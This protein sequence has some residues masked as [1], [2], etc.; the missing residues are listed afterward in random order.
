MK[1]D[2]ELLLTGK[3]KGLAPG[4]SIEKLKET[5]KNPF[6]NMSDGDTEI[7]SDELRTEFTFINNTLHFIVIK[8]FKKGFL[9]PKFSKTIKRLQKE[10]ISWFFNRE[11][12]L[13]DQTAIRIEATS[14]DLIFSVDQKGELVLGKV[15]LYK[16]LSFPQYSS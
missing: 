8:S 5:I 16:P 10:K 6:H 3:Y 15:G 2:L 11:L 14:V 4:D 13:C 12:T 9:S 7:Y 1:K